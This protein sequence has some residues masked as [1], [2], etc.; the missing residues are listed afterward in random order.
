M[1]FF[2]PTARLGETQTALPRGAEQA[3]QLTVFEYPDVAFDSQRRRELLCEAGPTD[4]RRAIDLAPNWVEPRDASCDVAL[5]STE[6]DVDGEL[7]G[8][9]E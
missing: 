9:Y 6:A 2:S 5:S 4:P 3:R 8:T 7:Q 1:N